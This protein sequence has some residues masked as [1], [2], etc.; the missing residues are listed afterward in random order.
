LFYFFTGRDVC[1]KRSEHLRNLHLGACRSRASAPRKMFFGARKRTRTSTTVKSQA[2]ETCASASSAIRARMLWVKPPV[3]RDCSSD[4]AFS[5]CPPLPALSTKGP[6]RFDRL[7]EALREKALS[8]WLSF[9][10]HSRKPQETQALRASIYL[11]A[12]S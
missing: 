2:S 5:L 12:S 6:H 4:E 3:N 1:R 8:G 9:T 10:A 7:P 11:M